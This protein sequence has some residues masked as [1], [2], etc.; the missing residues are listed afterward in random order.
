MDN[1][2]NNETNDNNP[3][4]S[5]FEAPDAN[6]PL[7]IEFEEPYV[8]APSASTTLASAKPKK[9]RKWLIPTIASL[10]VAIEGCY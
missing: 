7:N 6:N 3:I 2:F 1:N 10:G 4:N 8:Q 5:G 9:S